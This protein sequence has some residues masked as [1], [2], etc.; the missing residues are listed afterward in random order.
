MC[1]ITAISRAANVSSIPDMRAFLR[2]AALAIEPRGRDATGFAWVDDKG[3]WY[4]KTPNTAHEAVRDAP[5]ALHTQTAI[6][7][8]RMATKGDRKYSENNHPVVDDGIMLVHN[9]IVSNDWELYKML[10]QDFVKKAEVDT[11]ALAAILANLELLNAEHPVDVLDKPKGSAAIAWI[12]TAADQRGVLHLARLQERPMTIGWTRKGDLVMSSTP[13]TLSNL[14]SWANVKIRDFYEVPEGTYLRVENGAIVERKTFTPAKS[15]YGTYS[16]GQYQSNYSSGW[17]SGRKS[18][19]QTVADERAALYDDEFDDWQADPRWA[20]GDEPVLPTPP[21]AREERDSFGLTAQEYEIRKIRLGICYD[22]YERNDIPSNK[23]A[24]H[25]EEL[26][27]LEEAARC[28]D[29]DIWNTQLSIYRQWVTKHAW[30]D[31]EVIGP[32]GDEG[33]IDALIASYV[34]GA[35]GLWERL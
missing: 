25:C 16:G 21:S 7:H 27:E 33:D 19:N 3:Q 11:A 30:V 18:V 31:A 32:D 29:D 34:Q 5:L 23:V 2:L 15:T 4:W 9:G 12:N 22:E 6:G 17:E 35:D 8:T 28:C 20:N 14:S 24:E 1:G 13:E 10:G 26:E